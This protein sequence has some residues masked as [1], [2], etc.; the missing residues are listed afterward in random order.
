MSKDQLLDVTV[1]IGSAEL[2]D[3]NE[4]YAISNIVRLDV[5][6][7]IEEFIEY[8]NAYKKVAHSD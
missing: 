7:P 1:I 4:P 5:E 3:D 8:L 2:N 6:G